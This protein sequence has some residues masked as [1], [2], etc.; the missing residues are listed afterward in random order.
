MFLRKMVED[1]IEKF[2]LAHIGDV[3]QVISGCYDRHGL[4]VYPND[5]SVAYDKIWAS[6]VVKE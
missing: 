4:E 5:L 1:D 2:K 6:D 3:N